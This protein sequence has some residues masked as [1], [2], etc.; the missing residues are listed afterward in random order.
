VTA[1]QCCDQW[2]LPWCGGGTTYPT[3]PAPPP[4][5]TASA[6]APLSPR[7][8]LTP[9]SQRC[10][11]RG[12]PGGSRLIDAEQYARLQTIL[13]TVVGLPLLRGLAGDL[14]VG[15]TCAARSHGGTTT[16]PWV[17]MPP[18]RAV[19]RDDLNSSIMILNHLSA[20]TGVIVAPMLL[21]KGQIRSPCTSAYH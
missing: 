10:C 15:K 16:L 2:G 8:P 1:Q 11:R 3:P 12:Y 6:P 5:L 18:V 7:V 9:R 17:Q 21:M 4:S 20:Y 13:S 19:I 14:T